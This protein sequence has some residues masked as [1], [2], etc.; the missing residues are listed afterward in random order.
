[1]NINILLSGRLKLDDY[2]KGR[3]ENGDSTYWLALPD[4]STA[5]EVTRGTNIPQETVALT[6]VNACKSQTMIP[7][8][9][10]PL[11]LTP[12]RY[13]PC[14]VKDVP[15]AIWYDAQADQFVVICPTCRRLISYDTLEALRLAMVESER[16]CCQGC[17]AKISLE[18]NPGLI[19]LY[20]DFWSRTYA[21][22]QSPSWLEAI[23]ANYY[24]LWAEQL[25]A[26]LEAATAPLVSA[27]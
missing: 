23:S 19:G 18:R 5:E 11:S 10:E 15:L 26:G 14:A 24:G 22:P 7:V 16:K 20:L 13:T 21:W 3:P 27:S 25:Q 1:M 12:P 8:K 6:T 9:A 17:R 2:G 4:G